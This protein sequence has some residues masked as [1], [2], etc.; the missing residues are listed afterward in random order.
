MSVDASNDILANVTPPMQVNLFYAARYKTWG[1]NS[2]Q[3]QN[4]RILIGQRLCHMLLLP[5]F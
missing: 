2:L 4:C 3:N 1:G 5:E